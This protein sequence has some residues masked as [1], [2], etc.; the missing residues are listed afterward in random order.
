MKIRRFFGKDMRDALK[1]VKEELGGDAVIMSNKKVADGVEIVAAYDREPVK[2]APKIPAQPDIPAKPA[3]AVP[4]LSEIIGD[5][6]PDTLRALLEKQ[7]QNGFSGDTAH[8]PQSPSINSAAEAPAKPVAA[9]AP[10]AQSKALDDIREELNSLRDV[11]QF[12]VAGLLEQNQ[13]RNHPLQG[14][15]STRLQE[16]GIQRK[17]VDELVAFAPEQA[18]EREA[19]VF[20]LK[21]LANRVK[22]SKDNI[23][24]QG[25]VVALLGPT[26]SG[27]TTTIAKLA[28]QFAQQHGADQ[29]A[30][31]TV[32]NYRIAAFEQLATYGRIIGCNVKKAQSVEQLSDLLYQ[33]KDK[34]LV[35]IDTAG[36]GQKDTRLIKQLD[37]LNESNCANIKKYLVLQTNAQYQVM[38]QT[39]ATY[40]QTGLSGCIFSKLDECYSLGEAISA[41]VYHGLP[42]SYLTDG[43][44]VPE[45]IKIAEAKNLIST[46]ARLYKKYTLP[47]TTGKQVVD[48]KVAV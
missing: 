12:Q 15:L 25:G 17:L 29:V 8:K 28:A 24:E 21:L 46:A 6:G 35:L 34:K 7:A 16:M 20:L 26:G 48:S 47:H 11:L 40:Q 43:Q 23:L 32:D 44:R 4:T 1:Q 45:D 36:F 41:V 30:L 33:F 2:A 9:S 27:K 3:R 19:W 13:R 31:I 22:V 37:T 42:V 39:I 14:Y 5:D 18:D 38:N 10:V